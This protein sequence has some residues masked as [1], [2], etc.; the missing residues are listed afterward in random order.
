[1]V[2]G[3][4]ELVALLGVEEEDGFN[5]AGYHRVSVLKAVLIESSIDGDAGVCAV[6]PHVFDGDEAVFGENEGVAGDAGVDGF[7]VAE[8]RVGVVA[9]D[10]VD[11]YDPGVSGEV[12]GGHDLVPNVSGVQCM[13]GFF[14]PGVDQGVCCAVLDGLHET[15]G[16]GD[17]YVEILEMFRCVL[18]V[19]ELQ[20]VGVVD[21]EDSHVGAAACAALFDN[22]GCDV[23]RPDEADGAGGDAPRGADK[24]AFGAKAAEGESGAAAAFVY[25][26]GL[27]DAFEDGVEGVVDGEDEACGELLESGA[28][29]H[30]GWGIGEEKEGYHQVSEFCGGV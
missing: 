28:C 6:G 1:M 17:G 21:S 5:A 7:Y 3:E 13:N 11:E 23:K 4:A 24:V 19:Y 16:N 30:E 2:R 8:V 26:G 15:V 18:G 12:G 29:V 20:D 25:E 9:V 22:V 14:R 10:L 27:F